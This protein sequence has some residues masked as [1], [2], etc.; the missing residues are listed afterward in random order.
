MNIKRLFWDIE[1]SP[2]VCLSW[3][4]GHKINLDADNIVKERAVICIGYKWQHEKHPR[5]LVWDKNQCDKKMLAEFA[6]VA[7]GATEMVGHNCTH[8]DTKIL[9]SDLRYV[10]AGEIKVG[11]E[12][13][14]F[15]ESIS[16][17]GKRR[18]FKKTVVTHSK[19]LVR[20]CL[21]IEFSDGSNIIVTPEHRFLSPRLHNGANWSWKEAKDFNVGDVLTR[22]VPMF[23]PAKSYEAGYLA[24]FYDGEGSVSGSRGRDTG[25][26]R[27]NCSQKG[28]K[29]MGF[30]RSTMEKMGYKISCAHENG[31]PEKYEM[32]YQ[33]NLCGKF[34]C[35]KFLGEIRPQRLINNLNINTIGSLHVFN[36][37]SRTKITRITPVGECEIQEIT[38]T[39]KTYISDGFPSHNCDQFDMPWFKTRCAFHGIHCLPDYKT[40]D[41]LQWARRRF[42][43]NSNRLNYIA[44]FF[45]IGEKLKTEFG[46]W[47]AVINGDEK[48]L[49]RMARYCKRDVVLL[50]KVYEKIAPLSPIKTHVG[51]Y[52]G[53]DKWTCPACA[54]EHVFHRQRRMSALGTPKHQLQ[55]QD[56]GRHYFVADAVNEK[57]IE[58]KAKLQ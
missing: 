18:R 47:K 12:L 2:N 8:V 19:R 24:G 13:V 1:T 21:K 27:I 16:G 55:C 39:E 3:R 40:A 35:L 9:T 33:W 53:R 14:G 42:L 7:E 17:Q 30:V 38:T 25:T 28:G 58:A 4:V 23:H 37:D 52:I 5:V 31:T 43:F 48:A 57:R 50:Q 15:D 41:T 6:K 49:A 51:T 11:D 56:C 10:P 44:K 22:I 26:I 20:E 45:G 32:V 29:T 54:S 36:D 34:Q 46:L